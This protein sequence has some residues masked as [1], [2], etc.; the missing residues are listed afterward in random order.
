[1]FD[2]VDYKEFLEKGEPARLFP[3]ASETSKEARACAALLS[4]FMAVPDFA[5]DLLSPLG[6]PATQRAEIQCITEPVFKG[7]KDKKLRPDGLIRVVRGHEEWRALVE[8]KVGRAA[9]DQ[10]Q[11]EAYL[12]LARENDCHALITVSNQFTSRPE[13]HPVSVNGQLVRSVKLFHWSWVSLRSAAVMNAEHDGIEDRE[14]EFIVKELLRYLGHEKSGISDFEAMSPSWKDLCTAVRQQKALTKTGAAEQAAVADWH[15]L[16][17]SLSLDMSTRVGKAVDV[18]LTHAL[19]KD[20]A[21]RF[22]E[23]LEYLKNENRLAAELKIPNAS[24]RLRLEVSL[25]HRTVSA[26]MWVDAPQDKTF[27]SACQT[28]LR[29]QLEACQD[30]SIRITAVYRGRGANPEASLADVRQDKDA[31]SCDDRKR[32]PSGYWIKRVEPMGAKFNSAKGIVTHTTKTAIGFYEDVGQQLSNWVA[33]P[34]KVARQREP[35]PE[36]AADILADGAETGAPGD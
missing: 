15:Q 28:W 35:L 4:T 16:V 27:A 3:I 29:N 12:R 30:G 21:K 23:D 34:P 25:L 36:D 32:L 8:A 7:Q 19:K 1:V 22:S 6:A 26:E 2:C 17:R 13:V 18:H 5:K 14:Q 31:L 11:L 20:P 9:L 10:E 24:S 33:P